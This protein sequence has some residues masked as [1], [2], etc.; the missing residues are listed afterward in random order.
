MFGDEGLGILG[1]QRQGRDRPRVSDIAQGDAHIAQQPAPLGPQERRAREARLERR[2]VEGQ[3]FKQ[4]GL[5]QIGS[6]VFAQDRS[7]ARKAVP[8][9]GGQAIVAAEDACADRGAQVF[10]NGT[11]M[12]DGE[13]RNTPPG[14]QREGRGQGPGRAGREAAGAGTAAVVLGRI[15]FQIG[16]RQ[17]L[18]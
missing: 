5:G 18:R 9:T 17:D 11:P 14:I 15:G 6:M 7:G 13:V 12:L 16:R 4:I 8:R 2:F 10:G 1:R 3:Q